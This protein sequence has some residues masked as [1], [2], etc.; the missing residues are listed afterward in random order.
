[1]LQVITVVVCW[2]LRCSLSISGYVIDRRDVT[3]WMEGDA[4]VRSHESKGRG[5]ESG[6]S[7]IFFLMTDIF[8]KVYLFL[9]W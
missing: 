3:P 9:I 5:L 7:K 1:M 4:L 2:P 8:V 6:A